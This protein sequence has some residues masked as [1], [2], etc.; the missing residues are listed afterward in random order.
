MQYLSSSIRGEK[1]TDFSYIT[2]KRI[3]KGKL[4][5]SEKNMTFSDIAMACGY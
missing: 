1:K 3:E 5:L 2:K 4:H